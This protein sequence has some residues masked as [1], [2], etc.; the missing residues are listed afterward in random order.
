MLSFRQTLVSLL[1]LQ[2]AWSILCGNINTTAS[3]P[4][5]EGEFYTAADSASWAITSEK[6][7][8]L[9]GSGKQSLYDDFIV[10]CNNALLEY[11]RKKQLARTNTID[12]SLNVPMCREH[13]QYRIRMN[14]DQP[15]SVY[16]Y[17][18]NGYAKIRTPPSLLKILQDFWAE[19]K[20]KAE[21]EWKDVNVYH[22]SWEAP[23]TIAYLN[24]EHTGGSLE[25]QAK[26]WE[27]AKPILEEWTGQY[28]TPVSLYGIRSYHNG[29]I[30]TPHV[31]RMP[32]V[33]SAI[34]TWLVVVGSFFISL[35]CFLF[36]LLLLPVCD[37]IIG[38]TSLFHG[39][40][41]LL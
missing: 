13:D 2:L 20:D 8:P 23:T 14:R 26:I 24:K 1:F 4:S 27:E 31:D 5:Q 7:S 29:S 33:T 9:L 35:L 12:E 21:I 17:T 34:S 15:S 36:L 25:L 41:V 6:L 38:L 30:L 16:N 22:N 28:L 19:N 32:L 39:Y 3:T 10:G 37:A 40:Y 18:K 11:Q